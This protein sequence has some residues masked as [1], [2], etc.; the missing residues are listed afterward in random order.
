MEVTRITKYYAVL[1][2]VLLLTPAAIYAQEKSDQ[3]VMTLEMEAEMEAWMSLA[4]PGLHHEHLAPFVG[5]WKG[6]AK[7]W[8]GPDTPP[9]TENSVADVSWIMGGRFLKWKHTGNFSGMPFRGLAIEGYNNGEKRYE[10][11]WVDNFG[12]LILNYTGSCSDDG[13]FREMTTQFVDAVAGGTIDYRS[14]YTWIDDNHFT[15]T[16]YMDKGD[17]EFKNMVI[18]YERQ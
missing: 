13:K 5:S 8:M 12:T 16:A 17:G 2:I 18:T 11:V 15:F 10:S 4:Q 3:P 9:M 1:A 6:E 14:E 7:M